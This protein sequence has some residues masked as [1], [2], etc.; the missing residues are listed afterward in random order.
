MLES[1][2]IL[3]LMHTR[4]KREEGGGGGGRGEKTHNGIKRKIHFFVAQLR[5]LE[6]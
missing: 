4:P 1:N 5:I 6:F 3:N 2:D